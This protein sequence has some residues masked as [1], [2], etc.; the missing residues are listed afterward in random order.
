MVYNSGGTILVAAESDL[1]QEPW[2]CLN[3]TISGANGTGYGDGESNTSAI[4]AAGCG[5]AAASCQN[6]TLNGYSDWYLPSI[7][8]LISMRAL[9]TQLGMTGEYWSSTQSCGFASN[10]YASSLEMSTGSNPCGYRTSSLKVRPL[11]KV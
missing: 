7:N 4:V 1:G 5:G 6:L 10:F 11:R 9:R 8:E 3:K 2:G